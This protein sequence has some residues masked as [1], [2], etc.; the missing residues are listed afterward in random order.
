MDLFNKYKVLKSDF[1]FVNKELES[2]KNEN[3]NLRR[4]NQNLKKLI[5]NP[6]SR[7]VR[8]EMNEFNCNL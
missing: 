3:I 6:N 1:D 7:D 2:L 5:V 4:Q 8:S